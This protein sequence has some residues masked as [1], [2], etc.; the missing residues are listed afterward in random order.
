MTMKRS[1]FILVFG[2]LAVAGVAQQAI[3]EK[4]DVISPVIS[5][6]GDVTFSL[7][8]PKA[9]SVSVTGDFVGAP[10][11]MSRDSLGVWSATVSA[12]D[13]EIYIYQYMVD[14]VKFADPSNPYTKRDTSTVYSL[15]F[16]E[17]DATDNYSVKDVP[18]GTVSHVWYP[19][20]TL[21]TQ[22]RMAVYTP[23]M[24]GKD[25]RSYPV[26][27]L[28][29]GMGGDEEAW[30]TLGRTAQIMDNLIAKGLVEP[31]IVVLP[32]GNIDLPSAP[33]EGPAGFERP[34]TK[35]PHTMDG[36]YE[37]SFMDI[38]NFVDSVYN[39]RPEKASRAVAGLSMGGFNALN[40]SALYPETFDYV[41][42]FS[43]AI[44][45]RANQDDALF[46]DREKLLADQFAG[47]PALYWIGIGDSDFL[48][49]EN[50]EY[51][52]LL[53]LKGYPYT[54]Y[55]STGGHQWKNWRKYLAE[56]APL[57]FKK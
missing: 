36:A 23:L 7:F 6:N 50:K 44:Q 57:L 17:G 40:I 10:L 55:E 2:C 12:M 31:M 9:E 22:R 19:S 47:S 56:F 30:L 33:G 39:T 18:H 16:V 26:L 27:Y 48:Y 15:L 4:P 20:P 43:A 11:S 42:L 49:D 1:L 3:Y 5:E 51:R 53:T 21:G 25:G 46:T 41:G 8:A 34:T 52:A 38:V 37:K 32:N 14:G 13:P 29:H 45:P 54:Y 24:Y 28:L 35:L